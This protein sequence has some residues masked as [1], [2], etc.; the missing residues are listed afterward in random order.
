[1]NP[2]KKTLAAAKNFVVDHKIPIVIVVTAVATAAVARKVQYYGLKEA[3][4][5]IENKGLTDDFINR[6]DIFVN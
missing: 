2:A 3:Y 5:F 1:M 4:E 6:A